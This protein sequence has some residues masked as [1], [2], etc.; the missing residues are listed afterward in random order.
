LGE[1]LL[2]QRNEMFELQNGVLN[3]LKQMLP[4]MAQE[5]ESAL[6]QL[7]L[8][9]AKKLSPACPLKPTWLRLSF[10]KH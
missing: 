8:A 4:Q 10:A 1:Q 6:I 7:A 5:M 3:S 9:S 2:Q